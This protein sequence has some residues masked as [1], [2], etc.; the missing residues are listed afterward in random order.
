MR[1]RS[2]EAVSP[3][4]LRIEV[5]DQQ[6]IDAVAQALEDV[7]LPGILPVVDPAAEAPAQIGPS[8]LLK[9]VL[10][11]VEIHMGEEAFPVVGEDPAAGVFLPERS[12]IRVSGYKIR[13]G[14]YVQGRDLIFFQIDEGNALEQ[15]VDLTQ[16]VVQK[17]G[18]Q[19]L[20][21]LG[22]VADPEKGAVGIL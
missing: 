8:R 20:G 18:L 21:G 15:G 6:Q 17:I 5:V 7:L 9:A 3:K 1:I 16:G 22:E 13:P 19:S 10:Q 4:L 2:P 14:R 12:H 11:G